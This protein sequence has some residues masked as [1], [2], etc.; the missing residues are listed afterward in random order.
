MLHGV[1]SWNICRFSLETVVTRFC[2]C[3]YCVY[4]DY[5]GS[6]V[7]TIG[8][9]SAFQ[10]G[11]RGTTCSLSQFCSFRKLLFIHFPSFS[12]LSFDFHVFDGNYPTLGT[13]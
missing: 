9:V 3:D 5:G 6:C 10:M 13:C 11:L 7:A 12:N 1:G 4:C 2:Y 8:E